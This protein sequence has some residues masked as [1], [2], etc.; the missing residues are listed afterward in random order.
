[1]TH[2]WTRRIACWGLTAVLAL[3]AAGCSRGPSPDDPPVPTVP[4]DWKV[5]SDQIVD[6]NKVYELES[7]LE[8]RV[9]TARASVYQAGTEK[10]QI[11]TVV[12]LS[13]PEADKIYRILANKKPMYGYVRKGDVLF[14]FVAGT[15][16]EEQVKRGHEVLR[17]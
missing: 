1:M 15:S 14:E 17:K 2:M 8:G 6:R 11:N 9:K 7:R 12:A 10:V 4:S 3:G 16:A 5:I 13:G